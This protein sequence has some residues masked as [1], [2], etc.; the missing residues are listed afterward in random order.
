MAAN[1]IILNSTGTAGLPTLA[2]QIR[3]AMRQLTT[4]A[5]A[6]AQVYAQLGAMVDN[7]VSPP[8]YAAIESALGLQAGQGASLYALFQAANGLLDNA[9]FAAFTSSVI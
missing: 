7:G 8:S 2:I 4:N 1:A 6:L 3:Q 5:G 9:D